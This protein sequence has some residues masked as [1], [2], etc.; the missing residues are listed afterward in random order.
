MRGAGGTSGGAG[1]FFLGI[2]MMC[3]G[4]YLLFTAI[5]VRSSFGMGMSLY[6]IPAMGGVNLTSGMV[7]IPFIFGVGMVF[8]NAKNPIGWVLSIGSLTALTF[9]VISSLHFHMRSMSA[10]ELITIL[11][12]AIGGV[13]LFLRS[14]KAYDQAEA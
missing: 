9:G 1:Q 7:M 11:V 5:T 4:F 14:L 6:H 13:G 10:F 8:Y 3:G 2:I 12:L